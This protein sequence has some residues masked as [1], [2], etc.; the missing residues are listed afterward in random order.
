MKT[1]AVIL[2]DLAVEYNY[3]VVNGIVSFFEDKKDVRLLIS[4]VRTP[5]AD[6]NTFDYQF[7]SSLDLVKSDDVDGYIIIPN[8]FNSYLDFNILTDHLKSIT[9]KPVVSV[10]VPLNIKNSHYTYISCKQCYI[11]VIKHLKEKHNYTKIAFFSA[12]LAYSPEGLERL[13]AFKD[14]MKINNLEFDPNLVLPG[15]FTPGTS[16]DYILKHYKTKEDFPFQA[17]V[18]A[19]DFT[20]AGCLMAFDRLGIKCPDDI[21]LFGF[22][23]ASVALQYHP[24]LSTI[25]QFIPQSGYVAA[26]VIYDKLNGK[27]ISKKN[28]IETYPVYRQS[29]GCIDC[30]IHTDAFYDNNGVFHGYDEQ[31]NRERFNVNLSSTD[32]LAN[33]YQLLNMMDSY[34]SLDRIKQS[35]EPILRITKVSFLSICMYKDVLTVYKEEDFELPKNAFL[36]TL[37]DHNK[38]INEQYFNFDETEYFNP[39]KTLLPDSMD[40]K[41]PGIY[42]LMPIFLRNKNY[43]YMMCRFKD[44][45]SYLITI[46][47]KI[48]SNSFIQSYEFK[49]SERLKEKLLEKTE[50]LDLQS[51]TDELTTVFNRR[52]FLE[53]GERLL[54]LS[55]AV[56]KKG[57]IFFGDIDGLKTINDTYGHKTGDLAIRTQA[58]ILLKSFRE[59]DLVGRLSG[60]EFA[61]V[62]PGFKISRLED[63]KHRVEA[64]SKLES[65]AAGLPFILSISL[66]Y[67]AYTE[68]CHSIQELLIAA[69]KKL[70]EEKILKH[71]NKENLK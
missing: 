56:G 31:A 3:T 44:K 68:D 51:K 57:Y 35:L 42:Y 69:D 45:N 21:A 53:Y 12:E 36:A 37:V 1:I 41:Q 5:H 61:V 16:R 22:D 65:A 27:K 38:N 13:E 7:W 50:N 66:G 23:D 30:S 28:L 67:E 58:K 33:I 34:Y 43:G 10:A 63:L 49:K 32:N 46:Y 2:Y 20:A 47:S 14:A 8:S 60:D 52:G 55:V 25:N 26:Q 39:Q 70:Y 4:T 24:T 18:C 17:I 11:D 64:I 59:T 54:D 48:L 29:C 40:I 6:N 15:D 9:K 71:K 19:N 62:A